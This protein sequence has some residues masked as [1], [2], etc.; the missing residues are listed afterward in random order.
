MDTLIVAPHQRL[1]EEVPQCGRLSV[2]Q[3][4]LLGPLVVKQRLAQ[5]ITV[6]NVGTPLKTFN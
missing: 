3:V 6:L 4:S 1:V 5:T 2:H